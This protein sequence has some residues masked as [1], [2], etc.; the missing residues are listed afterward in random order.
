MKMSVL[1]IFVFLLVSGCTLIIPKYTKKAFTCC[2]KGYDTGLDTL[3]SLNGFYYP[4]R[5]KTEIL[6]ISV[7]AQDTLYPAYVF[8]KDGFIQVDPIIGLLIPP[9]NERV[10]KWRQKWGVYGAYKLCGDT[11]KAQYI[12]PPGGMTREMGEVWFKIINKNTLLQIFPTHPNKLNNILIFSGMDIKLNPEN[13]WLIKKKWFW[14][15]TAYK[16]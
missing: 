1:V 14:C 16:R 9:N 6:D 15:K 7:K 12:D 11:I 13:T 8:S 3:L 4:H 10:T 2:Y 5:D